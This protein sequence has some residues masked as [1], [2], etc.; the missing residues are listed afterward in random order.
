MNKH[1]DKFQ[2]KIIFDGIPPSGMIPK[3]QFVYF[4][5]YIYLKAS[6]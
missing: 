2:L 3:I 4:S 5:L 1:V 6:V